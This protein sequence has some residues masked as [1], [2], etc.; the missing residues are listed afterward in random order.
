MLNSAIYKEIRNGKRYST[1]V[2]R[3]MS[4]NGSIEETTTGNSSEN[5]EVEVSEIHTST[6]EVVNEQ[7]IEF[8]APPTR[9]LQELTRLVQGVVTPPHPS[10]YPRADFG[11]TS[12]TT[13]CQ[14]DNNVCFFFFARNSRIGFNLTKL[15]QVCWNN[16]LSHEKSK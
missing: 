15:I 1:C 13:T 3:A 11:T 14:S 5:V 12:G 6:Q 9:Q 16:G 4:E 7:I 2:E 8:I 10:H